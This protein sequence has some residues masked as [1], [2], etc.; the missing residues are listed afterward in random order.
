MGHLHI[1]PDVRRGTGVVCVAAILIATSP[2]LH[3]AEG[4]VADQGA[5][6]AFRNFLALPR[7]AHQYTASRRLE[8][9]G[10][11]HRAWLDVETNF[12]TTSGMLYEVTAEGGSG[13][14]RSRVLRSLLDEE[15]RLIARRAES[16]VALTTDNY[17]FVPEGINE[18]GLAVVDMRPLRKDRGLI[19]GQ[20]LMTVDGDLQRIEGRLAKNPSFWVT[21]VNVVRSYRRI[22]GVLMPV[23]L[24]TT[25]QLRLLGASELRMTYRYSQVDERPV[26]DEALE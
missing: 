7:I 26:H 19:A 13:Y 14:V 12:S 18:Q 16:R 24:D 11:G 15:Q 4:D 9:S 10:R 20:M 6:P 8:A 22:N 3:V 1:L 21:R 5:L 23:S 2:T 25:A 17:Q